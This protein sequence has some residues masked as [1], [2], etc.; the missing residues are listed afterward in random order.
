M[1]LL[2]FST[3]EHISFCWLYKRDY[4]QE[5]TVSPRPMNPTVSQSHLTY[6]QVGV[7]T[8]Q[9]NANPSWEDGT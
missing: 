8:H 3:E 7:D 2:M 5:M 4:C 1:L 6:K 9:R